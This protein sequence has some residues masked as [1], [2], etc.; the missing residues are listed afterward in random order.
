MW[1]IIYSDKFGRKLPMVLSS[2]GSL[3]GVLVYMVSILILNIELRLPLILIGS[4]LNGIAG[5]SSVF[6]M[7]INSY[8]SDKTQS[9]TRTKTLGKVLTMGFFGYCAGSLLAGL[10]QDVANTLITYCVV[11]A[12]NAGILILTI[13]F[14]KESVKQ[15]GDTGNSKHVANEKSCALFSASNIKD[16][17]LVLKRKREVN[18]RL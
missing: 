17:F 3:L 12:L 14:L 16:S 15:N 11:L 9:E 6:N 8:I 10:L 1:S 5:K 4:A 18:L 7:A 2:I 13:F